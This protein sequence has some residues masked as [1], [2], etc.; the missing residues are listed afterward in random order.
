MG[1]LHGVSQGLY[2]HCTAQNERNRQK[3]ATLRHGAGLLPLAHVQFWQT[4][5]S[6]R[7]DRSHCRRYR[8]DFSGLVDAADVRTVNAFENDR[9]YTSTELSV[10]ERFLTRKSRDERVDVG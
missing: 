10:A 5:D 8:R 3:Q 1:G 7:L 4:E 2:V 9:G 6:W